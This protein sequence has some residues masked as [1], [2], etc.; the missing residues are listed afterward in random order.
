M[1]EGT[2]TSP[3]I[4]R[5]AVI[6]EIPWPQAIGLAGLL[7]RFAA[8]HA[9]TGEIGKH[10]DEDI[11]TAL[12]WPGDSTEL[13]AAFVRSRLLDQAPNPT[14]LLVHDWPDHAPR[15]V[16]STL[17]RRGEDFSLL[18][19]SREMWEKM[20]K[21]ASAVPTTVPDALSTTSASVVST[22]SSS[23]STSTL[24]SSSA[25]TTT[26]RRAGIQKEW[27]EAIWSAWVPGRKSGKKVAVAAI[28][29]SIRD[30]AKEEGIELKE[31]ASI[32]AHQTRDDAAGYIKKIEAG[33]TELQFVPH[34]STYFKQE[35][36]NDGNESEPTSDEIR[37]SRIAH[38]I[39][40]ARADM[41]GE[42]DASPES[43]EGLV[44]DS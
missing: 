35:R 14:R 32:I 4:R 8:K 25:S 38:E 30:L 6:L 22:T 27:T 17:Q 24:P 31:A 13:V 39:R 37:E 9:P 21:E 23:S 1:L 29:R 34:G 41:D 16:R 42:L 33:E 7:W 28:E 11:A 12:E 26:A 36:W 44:A 43:L 19:S 5:L 2:Y 18:Y 15:Y 40:E 10:D 3:K 20:E